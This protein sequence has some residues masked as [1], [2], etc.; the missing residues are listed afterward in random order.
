[1]QLKIITILIIALSHTTTT[2]SQTDTIFIRYDKNGTD[3]IL[4]YQTDTFVFNVPKSSTPLVGTTILPWTTNQQVAKGYGLYLQSVR[5]SECLNNGRELPGDEEII[6]ITETDSSLIIET[7]IIGNCCHDFLC[8]VQVVEDSIVNLISYSYGTTYCA[9]AC[10]FGLTYEFS[11]MKIEEYE[12]L[13]YF[14][15]AGNRKTLRKK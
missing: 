12:K 1:M 7:K 15:I 13:K 14:M 2:W 9:C 4:Q 3:E 10:C 11:L 8:D 6:A 5:I